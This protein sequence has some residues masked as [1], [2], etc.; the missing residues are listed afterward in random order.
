VETRFPPLTADQLND[1]FGFDV[2]DIA[3]G[4]KK[5]SLLD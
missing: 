2:E 1:G 5:M 4:W 3:C